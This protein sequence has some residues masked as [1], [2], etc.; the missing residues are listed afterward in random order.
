MNKFIFP[1]I[2]LLMFAIGDV[3]AQKTSTLTFTDKCDG[4][5]TADDGTV[6]SVTSD[7]IESIFDN[8][9]GIHYGTSRTAVQYIQLS[10]SG[11][12]GAVSKIV[13][14]ASTAS[15]VDDATVNVNVGG[16]DFG[17]GAQGITSSAADYTFEGSASGEIIVT[18]TKPGSA[19]KALYVKSVIVTYNPVEDPVVIPI[20]SPYGG[21]F[22]TTQEVT[23]SCSTEGAEIYYTID[24]SDP[25]GASATKYERPLL[26]TQTTIVKAVAKKNDMFSAKTTAIFAQIQNNSVKVEN[27]ITKYNYWI[28]DN[29]ID[30][31]T[32]ELV[33]VPNPY[34]LIDMLPVQE[35]PI[36]SSSFHFEIVNNVPK[37]Y[38]KN[39]FHIRFHDARGYFVDG[40]KPFID[41]RVEN[42]VNTTEWLISGK[43]KTIEK[44]INNQIYWCKINAENGDSLQFK[45]DRAATIQ[46]FA[47]S[48]EE[49]HYV[50]GWESVKWNGLHVRESGTYYLA[51]HDV[52]A[53]QGN[54]LSIDYNHIDKYAVLQQDVSIVGNGGCS[55]ITFD[56]NGFKDLY[57]VDLYTEKGDTIHHVDI[58][59][60][61]DATTSVT[62]DF[63]GAKTGKYHALFRF[64][65]GD[66]RFKNM[67]TVEEAVDIELATTVSY[68]STFL[69]GSTTTYTLKITNNGNM[70]AYAVPI[71]I[72]ITS[73]T[74]EGISQL[75]LR[76]LGLKSLLSYFSDADMVTSENMNSLSE[77][78]KK[79]GEDHYF[80][81]VRAYDDGIRDSITIRSNLFFTNI[82]PYCTKEVILSIETVE[83]IETHFGVPT[84]WDA[85]YSKESPAKNNTHRANW[86]CCHHELIECGGDMF[87]MALDG[88][89]LGLL[90]VTG[91]GSLVLE[92]GSCASSAVS[93]LSSFASQFI[94]DHKKLLSW[95]TAGNTLSTIGLIASCGALKKIEYASEA[96][97]LLINTYSLPASLVKC[98]NAKKKKPEC[99]PSNGGTSRPVY[100]YDP[101][102]IYGYLAESGSNAVREGLTDVYYRI[103]FENDTAF[104]T[105]AAHQVVITDTLDAKKFDLSSYEPARVKIGEKT[106][107]LAGDK[108]FVT[109]VDMRPEI[110]AIAQ[111]T[112]KYD[113]QKGIAQWKI[114]SLD[115]MTM[116]PTDDPMEGVLPVN[117]NGSGIGEVSYNISLKPGLTHGS[118]V[119]NRAGIVFDNNEVIMTPTWTNIMDLVAPESR[120]SDVRQINDSVAVVTIEATDGLSGPWR[121]DVYVQY[122]EG[123]AWWKAAENVPVDTTATVKIYEGI[124]HSFY[125]V[126]TDSAGNVEQKKPVAEQRL[127]LGSV[128]TTVETPQVEK[129]EEVVYDLQG[130]KQDATVRRKGVYIVTDEVGDNPQ[131]VVKK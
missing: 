55:T 79:L 52:T 25:K 105:A 43:R 28:N 99:T 103:E 97:S 50:F 33:N 126:A 49:L 73:R 4:S 63:S 101:N 129:S 125:V 69:R 127:N 12:P 89:S 111:V 120:A 76:G 7:G 20:I 23:F 45:L 110:N 22:S 35:E 67:L 66:K 114:E 59:H 77:L 2:S 24:G 93:N 30:I 57:A 29:T 6:W 124:N 85:T 17:D 112:G 83:N 39:E 44:P 84:E 19:K 72:N 95:S 118:E 31:K 37:I 109:T 115:P 96:V 1:F 18:V 102:D 116:E 122:G 14:N 36:R 27:C 131:K 47:P 68:P 113:E 38:A 82:A 13:V 78:S 130:R 60:E 128:S 92:V 80:H 81:K 62:F 108:N 91:G 21:I 41:Y 5:G 10:T 75:S 16:S 46:L 40:W 86:Y 8:N 3:W 90:A 54:T 121:Y 100:S 32:V 98:G 117:V 56:G 51:L 88:I 94:C 58:G 48:G 11:I 53:A 119:N 106:A 64:A 34:Q 9:K 26:L 123:S 107:D 87:S 42:T 15:Q 70:T 71:S 61:S 74:T 104:A 65:E